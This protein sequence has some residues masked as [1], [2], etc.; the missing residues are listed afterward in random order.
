MKTE[1]K[2][3]EDNGG[4]EVEGLQGLRMSRLPAPFPLFSSV[5]CLCR[6]AALAGAAGDEEWVSTGW[7]QRFKARMLRWQA[8]A[9]SP[10]RSATAVQNTLA[11]SR[12]WRMSASRTGNRG[13]GKCVRF[14]RLEICEKA[15]ENAKIKPN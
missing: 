4:N 10:L 15:N 12:Y 1:T 9:V 2:S 7:Q 5:K 11:R 6:G 3:T 13:T 8:K 14:G